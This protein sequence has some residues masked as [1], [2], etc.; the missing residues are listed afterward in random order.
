[1]IILHRSKFNA[2]LA[3]W[4]TSF[5]Q[6]PQKDILKCSQQGKKQEEQQKHTLN[7]TYTIYGQVISMQAETSKHQAMLKE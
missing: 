7:L 3:L 4:P 2:K 6:S 5:S 1:M